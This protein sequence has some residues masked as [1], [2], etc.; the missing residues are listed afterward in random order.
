MENGPSK[1]GD[2]RTIKEL[3]ASDQ[4]WVRR[5]SPLNEV[6]LIMTRFER[7][8]HYLSQITEKILGTGK[9]H[10]TVAEQRRPFGLKDM[11]YHSGDESSLKDAVTQVL[12]ALEIK[13]LQNGALPNA[14]R[15]LV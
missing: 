5:L 10:W 4:K 8:I 9:F 3:L 6:C 11:F 15:V 1:V 2:E 12:N 14:P 13:A 7:E